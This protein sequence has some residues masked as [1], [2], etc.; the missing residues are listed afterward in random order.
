M[1]PPLHQL[2]VRIRG[3]LKDVARVLQ[4]AGRMEA[5]PALLG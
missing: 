2:A 3:E 4:R 1:T 5:R